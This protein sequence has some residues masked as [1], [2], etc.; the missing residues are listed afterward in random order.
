MTDQRKADANRDELC[1]I[2]MSGM[3]DD[4]RNL[5]TLYREMA[6]ADRCYILRV[7]EVLASSPG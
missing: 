7:A 6:D 3:T 4:E 2:E 5:L 1:T